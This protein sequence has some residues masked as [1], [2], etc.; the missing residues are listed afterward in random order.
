MQKDSAVPKPPSPPLPDRIPKV[1]SE[2]KR[3][4]LPSKTYS[5]PSPS[6]SIVQVVEEKPEQYTKAQLERMRPTMTA[7]NKEQIEYRSDQ[8]KQKILNPLKFKKN[9]TR[10]DLTCQKISQSI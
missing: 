4:P 7:I 3:K 1:P 2:I 5:I 10:R 6:I 8:I 9:V